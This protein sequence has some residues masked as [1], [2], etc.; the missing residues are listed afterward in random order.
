MKIKVLKTTK[1]ASCKQGISTRD[2][3]EGETYEIFNELAEVFITQGWGVEEKEIK[4][5]EKAIEKA[6][7]N[8]MFTAELDNKAIEVI[9]ETKEE[10]VEEKNEEVTKN[11]IFTKKKKR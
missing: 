4:I 6:P 5:I 2:Y 1:A 8:K 9:E 10:V 7:E 3:L 11:K